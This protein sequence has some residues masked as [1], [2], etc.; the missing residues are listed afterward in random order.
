LSHIFISFDFE[1]L[2]S[3]PKEIKK[4]EIFKK[5]HIFL[6]Y[7]KSLHLDLHPDLVGLLALLDPD[8]D[9]YI[10]KVPDPH[11]E[12]TDPQH[13]KKTKKYFVGINLSTVQSRKK[14]EYFNLP[15]VTQL[16]TPGATA[17]YKKMCSCSKCNQELVL[18]SSI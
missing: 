12:Y 4:G 1:G 15:V 11:I 5:R 18:R 6:K 8:P 16:L 7:R 3:L 13:R 14:E 10:V 17:F 2:P 9:L